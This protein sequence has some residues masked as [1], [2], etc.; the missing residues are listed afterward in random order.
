MEDG[1]DEFFYVQR[2]VTTCL[3]KALNKLNLLT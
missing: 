3:R 1:K 2:F